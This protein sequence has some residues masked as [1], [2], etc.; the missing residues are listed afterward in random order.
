L[1]LAV[2]KEAVAFYGGSIQLDDQREAGATITVIIPILESTS[3][4]NSARIIGW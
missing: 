3:E 4:I 1:E 2:V